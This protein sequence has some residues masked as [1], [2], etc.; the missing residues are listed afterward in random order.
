MTP[1]Y[2]GI[3]NLMVRQAKD[4]AN[5]DAYEIDLVMNG[6]AISTG[7]VGESPAAAVQSLANR[8]RMVRTLQSELLPL[9]E[10]G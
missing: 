10:P 7:I 4:E 2:V 5:Q 9:Y 1:R 3:I 6:L 8:L